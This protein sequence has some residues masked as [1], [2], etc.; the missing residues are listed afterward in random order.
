MV[1]HEA[2]AFTAA[3]LLGLLGSTHCVGM[4]GGIS[5]ALAFAL[6][7]ELTPLG[8]YGMLLLYN[9]GRILSYTF[10][11]AVAGA[12]AG[13]LLRPE[14]PALVALRAVAGALLVLMGLYLAG[15]SRWLAVVERGG[16]RIWGRLQASGDRF[17]AVDSPLKA[18]GA[19]AIW[20][21]LPCGL[22]YST[23]AWATTSAN[24]LSGALLMLGFGLGT[25][26][27][28]IATG[29]FAAELRRLLQRRQLRILAGLV[30]VG[31]GL[32]TLAAVLPHAG[33][34]AHM[35]HH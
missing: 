2:P 8:R 27:A 35:H 19:G 12:L 32:W 26:P 7:R 31:F 1:M 3:V 16:Y 22:V 18:I 30:V 20:G 13:S 33:Q 24:P 11:G 14:G 23:L 15:W 21:W 17:I 4:C 9:A 28:V 6:G 5:G 25:L 29:A 10:M 34:G